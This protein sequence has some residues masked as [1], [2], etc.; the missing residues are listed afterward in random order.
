MHF[1]LW[2]HKVARQSFEVQVAWKAVR[3]GEGIKTFVNCEKLLYDDFLCCA[4][5]VADDVDLAVGGFVDAYA[6]QIVIA[7]DFLR[8]RTDF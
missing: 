4:V 3:D 1:A 2:T 8:R 7:F 5:G 6:L